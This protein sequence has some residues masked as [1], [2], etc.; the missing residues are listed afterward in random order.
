MDTL[1]SHTL[2]SHTLMSHTLMT[3][4]L[5]SHTEVELHRNPLLSRPVNSV[6]QPPVPPPSFIGLAESHGQPMHLSGVPIVF[7]N[8]WAADGEF[9]EQRPIIG[10]AKYR[11]RAGPLCCP[12]LLALDGAAPRTTNG[13]PYRFTKRD[14]GDVAADGK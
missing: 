3:H 11:D 8:K 5:K 14:D 6:V 10:V 12:L 4:T 2:M 9:A 1:M 13:D 7:Q